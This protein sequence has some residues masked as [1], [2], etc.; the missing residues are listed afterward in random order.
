MKKL[1]IF[2]TILLVVS[3]VGCN[4]AS[5]TSSETDTISSQIELVSSEIVSSS[6]EETSSEEIV[7]S[8][9]PPE[10]SS[11]LETSEITST[12]NN[13]QKPQP[14]RPTEYTTYTYIPTE[15]PKGPKP[16]KYSVVLCNDY[17]NGSPNDGWDWCYAKYAWVTKSVS[18]FNGEMTAVEW[19]IMLCDNGLFPDTTLLTVPETIENVKKLMIPPPTLEECIEYGEDI[20]HMRFGTIEVYVCME[21]YLEEEEEQPPQSYTTYVD[22]EGNVYD[23][24]WNYLYNLSE[25]G[26]NYY[27]IP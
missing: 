26:I 3:L 16:E 27:P 22:K 17:P 13:Y 6:I 2:I 11:Q 20:H 23:E 15:T 5:V 21:E 8:E 14:T 24:D 19:Q 1:L 18:S 25:W 9:Q 12:T 7:S 4:N 10:S